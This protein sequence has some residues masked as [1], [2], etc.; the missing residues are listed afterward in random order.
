MV[1]GGQVP[2]GVVTVNR[3]VGAGAVQVDGGGEAVTAVDDVGV[4]GVHAPG[5]VDPVGADDEVV[6]A[7]TVDVPGR[8][9][10][11]RAVIPVVAVNGQIGAGAAQVD[12]GGE[13]VAAVD[14]IG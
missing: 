11:A 1:A 5:R 6:G 14:H 8:H 10:E 3:Q 4:A 7:V 2:P 13:A 12:G 9:G